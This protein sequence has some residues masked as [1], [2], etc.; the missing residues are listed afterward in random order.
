MT[1]ESVEGQPPSGFKLRHTLRGHKSWISRIAW[2]PDGRILASPS[3]NGAIRL[4]DADGGDLLRTLKGYSSCF[5]VAWSPTGRLLTSGFR[6]SIIKLWEPES[7][8]LC[9][10]LRGQ[11]SRVNS[12]AWS[13]DGRTLAS[14]LS[15]V[16]VLDESSSIKLPPGLAFHPTAPVL[17][18]LGEGDTVI[19]IWD[20]DYSILLGIEPETPTVHY[21]NA[22]VVLVG[23]TG[24]GKTGLGLVLT[25]QP[26]VSTE[27]THGRHVLD[28][29]QPGGGTHRRARGDARDASV[30]P[31][32]PARLPPH[33]PVAPR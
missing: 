26:F 3:Y 10:T 25:G 24:V 22:K 13:P 31:G 2:S 27:S 29:R 8:K 9:Q 32:G 6:D 5:C 7:G 30:G 19:R 11:P 28:L 16:A 23:D 14:G 18:T 4:W 1:S 21:T 12:V 20:L 17:A 15:A 33:P